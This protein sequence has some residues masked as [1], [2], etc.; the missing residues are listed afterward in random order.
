MKIQRNE[1]LLS[2]QSVI[3]YKYVTRKIELAYSFMKDYQSAKFYV[4][5][6]R[7]LFGKHR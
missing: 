6:A 1:T 7:R 4:R 2:I 5:Q 3:G